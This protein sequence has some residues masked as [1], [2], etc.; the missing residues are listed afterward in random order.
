[1]Q[2]FLAEAKA[3]LHEVATDVVQLELRSSWKPVPF[4]GLVSA[5]PSLVL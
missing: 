1:M 3:Y 2:V 4:S 5:F